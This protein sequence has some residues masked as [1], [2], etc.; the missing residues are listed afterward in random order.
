MNTAHRVDKLRAIPAK[1]R[2]VSAEPLLES[3][4]DLDISGMNWLIAGGESGENF[5]PMRW[6]WAEELR[7]KCE[8][9]NVAYF[10]KQR[11][12]FQSGKG[13]RYVADKALHVWP[14]VNLN[15]TAV[16]QG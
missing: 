15:V 1:I 12:G 4:K 3:L 8:A 16:E 5:R 13:E 9:A 2:F 6:R 7:Q 11:A 10:F 14:E